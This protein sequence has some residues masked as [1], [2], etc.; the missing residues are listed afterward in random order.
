MDFSIRL[1]HLR[2]KYKLTQGE[3]AA[4]IGLKSTAISNYESKRNEPSFEKLISLSD[5]FNVSCDYMLGVTDNTLRIGS[6]D[7]DNDTADFFILYR[8]LNKVNTTEIKNY[9][10]YLLYKQEK[11]SESLKDSTYEIQKNRI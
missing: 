8:R 6:E 4:V 2:Q 9:A 5:Y 11:L 3:L 7:L 10:K 1:K